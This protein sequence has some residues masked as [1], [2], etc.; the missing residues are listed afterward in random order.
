MKFQ[1]RKV[2]DPSIQMHAMKGSYPDFTCKKIKDN[3]F[4]F[5]GNLQPHPNIEPYT[6]EITY[7]GG[8]DPEV[9]II[10]PNIDESNPH[11]YRSSKTLCLYRPDLFKWKKQFLISKYIVRWTA[12]WIYFYEVWLQT[13]VWYGPEAPHDRPKI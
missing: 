5:T 12:A 10:S 13:G 9:K 7:R 1:S 2:Y 6:V 4:I 8:I 3:K 11:F